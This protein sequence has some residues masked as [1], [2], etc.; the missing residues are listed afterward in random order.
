MHRHLFHA[1]IATV[2]LTIGLLAGAG[3]DSL[4]FIAPL[5]LVAFTLTSIA[6]HR[7]FTIDRLKVALLT[8]L[9]WIP[10]A[11][12]ALSLG[13]EMIGSAACPYEDNVQQSGT[14]TVVVFEDP[15]TRCT[16]ILMDPRARDSFWVGVVDRQARFKPKVAYQPRFDRPSVVPVSVLIDLSGEV[17]WSQSLSGP[18]EYRVLAREAACRTRFPPSHIDGQA[19]LFNGILTFR[20]EPKKPVRR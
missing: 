10:F 13:D 12:L 20:F 11:A 17:L 9:I 4:L 6:L 8:L 16:E 5:A 1:G 7:Y 3:L 14:P 18:S 2:A 19:P 15:G